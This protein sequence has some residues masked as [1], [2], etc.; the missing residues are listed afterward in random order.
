MKDSSDLMTYTQSFGY[1]EDLQKD[2]TAQLQQSE[3][4]MCIPVL[5]QPKS[6]GV[7]RLNSTSILDEPEIDA[8]H[9]DDEE[10]AETILRDIKAYINTTNGNTFL[11]NEKK[12]LK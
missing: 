6:L 2:C 8:N 5:L 7:L 1:N 11:K 4:L 3:I 9:F 10:D 12:C